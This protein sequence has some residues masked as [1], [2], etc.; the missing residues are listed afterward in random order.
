MLVAE[1]PHLQACSLHVTMHCQAADDDESRV[2]MKRRSCLKQSIDQMINPLIP[3]AA[4]KHPLAGANGHAQP[5]PSLYLTLRI[6]LFPCQVNDHEYRPD[7]STRQYVTTRPFP[8]KDLVLT[9]Y[10][11]SVNPMATHPTTEPS[12]LEFA[13]T[14]SVTLSWEISGLKD[15]FEKSRGEVKS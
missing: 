8:L 5:P 12:N 4:F 10:A 2:K 1:L 14:Q 15:I 7:H 6:D 13:E 9:S 11:C 3:S